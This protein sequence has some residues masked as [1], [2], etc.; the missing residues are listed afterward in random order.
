MILKQPHLCPVRFDEWDIL[1]PEE[2]WDLDRWWEV[3][4]Q[5]WREGV[6]WEL[7][8]EFGPMCEC[9]EKRVSTDLHEVFT[10]RS[11]DTTWRQIFLFNRENCALVCRRCHQS[12][13][14]YSEKFKEKIR[15]RREVI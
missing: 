7:V 11:H 2:G 8:D 4:V 13:V 9:C 15:K 3:V 10:P 1:E 5:R 6:K 12:P 14:I